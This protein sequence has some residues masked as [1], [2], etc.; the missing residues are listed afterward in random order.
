MTPAFSDIG[1][2]ISISS[3]LKG[4]G[5]SLTLLGGQAD[6]ILDFPFFL[7]GEASKHLDGSFHDIHP[8]DD[9][10]YFIRSVRRPQRAAVCV[11][12]GIA[13]EVMDRY[14]RM[15]RE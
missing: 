11:L 8:I 10:Q 12:P 13:L 5:N 2:M 14:F 9:Y 15:F 3:L 4:F 6:L 7:F 1:T